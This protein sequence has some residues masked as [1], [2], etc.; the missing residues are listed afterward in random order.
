MIKSN[1]PYKISDEAYLIIKEMNPHSIFIEDFINNKEK[2]ENEFFEYSHLFYSLPNTNLSI[3]LQNKKDFSVKLRFTKTPLILWERKDSFKMNLMWESVSFEIKLSD[4]KNIIWLRPDD[5]EDDDN[6]SLLLQFISISKIEISKFK[7]I[8]NYLEIYEY[9]DYL[10]DEILVDKYGFLLPFKTLSYVEINK[11]DEN[12]LDYMK[13]NKYFT[14]QIF[15]AK[16]VSWQISSISQLFEIKNL[17]PKHYS[18]AVYSLVN[19]NPKPKLIGITNTAL[20]NTENLNKFALNWIKISTKL[21]DEDYELLCRLLSCRRTKFRIE[22]VSLAL[23]SPLE[24]VEVLT[25]LTG[26]PELIYLALNNT[27]QRSETGKEIVQEAAKK[28]IQHAGLIG[29]FDL[30]KF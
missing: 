2:I 15:K 9:F 27:G 12:E 1:I 29:R 3:L 23:S 14:E 7:I 11:I 6:G 30:N 22:F 17:S 13:K 5:D 19:T 21:T 24:C 28:F 10:D 16:S 4:N 8:D 26:C 25:L 20:M 18:R